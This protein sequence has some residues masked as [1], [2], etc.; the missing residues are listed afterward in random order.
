MTVT[1]MRGALQKLEAEGHGARLC[2]I[3]RSWKERD[4][5]DDPDLALER[6]DKFSA[7]PP[8]Y[9]EGAEIVLL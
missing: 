9:P 6:I 1:E 8:S 7:E 2:V 5:Y 3:I 4:Y